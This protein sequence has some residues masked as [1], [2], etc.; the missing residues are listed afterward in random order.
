[1]I[2][3]L[4]KR[5]FGQRHH[6][7]EYASRWRGI[8]RVDPVPQPYEWTPAIAVTMS[9]MPLPADWAADHHNI[10]SKR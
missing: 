4:F 7:D 9:G 2:Q 3:R 5:L 8:P 1:M 6:A 10:T